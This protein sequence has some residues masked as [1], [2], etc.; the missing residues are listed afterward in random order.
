MTTPNLDKART[1][2]LTTEEVLA[3]IA[4]LRS[5]TPPHSWM[6]F[7]ARIRPGYAAVMTGTGREIAT[8]PTVEDVLL[9]CRAA[10]EA[11]LAA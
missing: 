2:I 7:E 5:I 8:G 6:A 1:D 4:E 9:E 3:A 10:I 11:E